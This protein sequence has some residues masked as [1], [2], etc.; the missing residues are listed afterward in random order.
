MC[1]T[2]LIE[3]LEHLEVFMDFFEQKFEP[4]EQ[5][6]NRLREFDQ[7][8]FDHL[9]YYYEPGQKLVHF[10]SNGRPEA[11]ILTSRKVQT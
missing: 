3:L 10:D 7:M 2:Y 5:K 1:K 6:L 9:I 11:L 8:E 4:V